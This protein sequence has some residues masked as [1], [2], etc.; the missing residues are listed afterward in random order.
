MLLAL[1]FFLA[2]PHAQSQDASQRRRR[3]VETVEVEGNRRLTA[4]GI[5]S[6]IKTRHG[7]VYDSQQV[8][9]DL[10][11][12]LDLNVFDKTQTRVFIQD[13]PKGGVVI[14]FHV[15][16]LP[17]IREVK[18]TGLR[19]VTGEEVLSAFRQR[20]VRVAKGEAYDPRQVQ[21]AVRILKELLSRRG[22]PDASVAISNTEV[23]VTEV[24]IEFQI[25]EQP[26]E[27]DSSEG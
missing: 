13:G 12:L 5:F 3:L 20:G 4:D 2:A 16:E 25:V 22:L 11:S 1:L 7:D 27:S 19:S 10:Q 6:H 26:S 18:F 21:R 15:K 8:R 23:S 24:S 17:V 14:I 9:R